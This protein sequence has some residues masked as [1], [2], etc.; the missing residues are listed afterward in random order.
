MTLN[1]EE[2]MNGI[3]LANQAPQA[4]LGRG[5]YIDWLASAKQKG[6][7][8]AAGI[9]YARVN[10]YINPNTGN[11]DAPGLGNSWSRVEADQKR[12]MEEIWKAIQ[13]K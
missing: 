1:L 2:R 12:R 7:T 10:S 8:G 5:G 4:A 11:L 3:D 9:L 6:L 13:K